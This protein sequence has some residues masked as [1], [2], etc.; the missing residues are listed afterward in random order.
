MA[1]FEVHNLNQSIAMTT[2]K[3]KL[4]K[5]PS[6]AKSLL[7]KA[8]VGSKILQVPPVRKDLSLEH[9]L[10]IETCKETQVGVIDGDTS[11]LKLAR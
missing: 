4:Q 8:L 11:M 1:T 9:F 7:P 5:Y 10:Q 2:L 6:A 3:S